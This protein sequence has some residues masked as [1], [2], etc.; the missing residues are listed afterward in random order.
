MPRLVRLLCL[1]ALAAMALT[2]VRGG[3]S[4]CYIPHCTSCLLGQCLFCQESYYAVNGTCTA[5]PVEHCTRCR[6]AGVCTACA[7]GYQVSFVVVSDNIT[8]FP[9]FGFCK[10]QE[11]PLT[12]TDPQCVSCLE[13][14][15][16]SCK[17]GYYPRSGVCTSCQS[18]HCAY[19]SSVG[20]CL[21][22]TPSFSLQYVNVSIDSAP[23][24]CWGKCVQNSAHHA[25][26]YVLALA[27]VA[28]AAVAVVG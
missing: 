20:K 19:C 14:S 17:S 28:A 6:P 9:P 22:C 23:A 27:A 16:L 10:T 18:D 8:T 1:V 3:E 15:C 11:T 5:C 7:A 26:T 13:G 2:V 12:C 24:D 21:S 25:N 4:T